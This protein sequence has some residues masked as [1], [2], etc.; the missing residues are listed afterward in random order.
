MMLSEAANSLVV[1]IPASEIG[2][3]NETQGTV[4]EPQHLVSAHKVQNSLNIKSS[5][6]Y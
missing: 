5:E 4:P 2:Y 6:D 3:R 1:Y